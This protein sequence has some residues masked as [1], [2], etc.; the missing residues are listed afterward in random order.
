MMPAA[1]RPRPFTL[2]VDIGGTG[3]KA[4]VLDRRGRP[5]TGRRRVR[6]PRPA[7]PAAVLRAIATLTA[8]VPRYDRVAVGFPGVV[9]DGLVRAAANLDPAW[10]GVNV[11]RRLE[12]L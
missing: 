3:I 12:R 11:V 7:R 5:V 9:E 8:D 1:R 10:I 4:A 2:S 6:T